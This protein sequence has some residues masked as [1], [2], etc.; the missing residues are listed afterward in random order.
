MPFCAARL[1]IHRFAI[2]AL[3]LTVQFAAVAAYGQTPITSCGTFITAPGRYV[4]ANDLTNCRYG[5]II[6]ATRDVEL[7]L[8]GH[9]ITG[10]SGPDSGAG[11]K[12]QSGATRVRIEGPGVISNFTARTAGGVLL[13]S[14]GASEVTGVTSTGNN[15]GFVYSQGNARIHGNFATNNVDGFF[16]LSAGLGALEISDNLA[17]GNQEDGIVTSSVQGDVRITHNTVAFNGRY[18]ISAETGAKD[19]NIISNTSLGNATFD[20]IDANRNCQNSWAENTFGT[21][22]GACI[23]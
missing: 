10:T 22:S 11:I 9:H 17:S 19:N 1:G 16:A 18:G 20:L 3:A 21:S 6:S 15:W 5:V 2:A 12:V 23:H 4:L 8:A 14:S 7:S 13:Y